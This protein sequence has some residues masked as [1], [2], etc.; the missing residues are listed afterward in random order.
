MAQRKG[1]KIREMS[2]DERT[3]TTFIARDLTTTSDHLFRQHKMLEMVYEAEPTSIVRGVRSDGQGVNITYDPSEQVAG[4]WR[5]ATAGVVESA[6]VIPHPTTNAYQ[7]WLSVR[8]T[9]GG[10][11]T[12]FI[13]VVDRHAVMLFPP[14]TI[15]NELTQEQETVSS[16]AGLTMDAATTFT[17]PGATFAVPHL[18]G[19]PVAVV[20]DGVEYFNLTAAPSTGNVTLPQSVNTCWIGLGFV[21]KGRGMPADLPVRGTTGQMNRRRWVK[22]RARVEG[23]RGLRIHGENIPFEGLAPFSGDKDVTVLGWNGHGMVAFVSDKSM[24]CTLLGI[25]GILDQENR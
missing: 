4:W 5:F 1:S 9:I 7:V 15:L 6:A 19:L 8:R 14:V 13:E 12:R 2:Y 25:Y 22:L 11:E 24:P 18:A 3:Q 10:G 16:W 23:A 20:A 21:A 17:G